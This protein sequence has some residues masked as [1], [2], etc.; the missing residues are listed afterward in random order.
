[1]L[2]GLDE[3]PWDLLNHAYGSAGDVPGLLRE[4]IDADAD[5]V[6]KEG[7]PLWELYGNIYHQ[8]TVYPATSYAVPFLIEL[9]ANHNVRLRADIVMLLGDIARSKPVG[10]SH[11]AV[12]AGM[13]VYV[14][15]LRESDN[16]IRVAAAQTL[17]AFP[18][19]EEELSFVLRQAIDAEFDPLTQ[20]AFLRVAHANS[21][22]S[23]P[24]AS[25]RVS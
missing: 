20:C 7:H 9:A 24:N 8:G 4:L 10:E 13:D 25:S 14:R 21:S 19:H 11:A 3:V 23:W 2:D 1:M 22:H 5:S 18:E 15:M 17:S 16:R 6:A 12:A